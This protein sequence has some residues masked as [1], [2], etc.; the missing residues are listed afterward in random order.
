MTTCDEN[1]RIPNTDKML[2]EKMLSEKQEVILIGRLLELVLIRESAG[3]AARSDD[4]RLA[5]STKRTSHSSDKSRVSGTREYNIPL[6]QCIYTR[7]IRRFP[8]FAFA[9]E[10]YMSKMD[11]FL[12][13]YSSETGCNFLGAIR[14]DMALLLRFYASLIAR[15][16]KEIWYDQAPNDELSMWCR[17]LHKNPVIQGTQ[18]LQRQFQS[19]SPSVRAVRIGSCTHKKAGPCGRFF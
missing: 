9:G 16:K 2:S 7:Y 11:I 5:Q 13:Q 4:L 15:L 1:F 6:L 10:A 18:N 12:V 17:N 14:F 3:M 19:I 8:L